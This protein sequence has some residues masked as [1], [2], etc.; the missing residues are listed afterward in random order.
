MHRW[1]WKVFLGVLLLLSLPPLVRAWNKPGHMVTGAIAYTVLKQESPE[2]LAK[3]V[4]ML[5]EHPYYESQWQPL[6]ERPFVPADQRDLYLFMLAAKWADDAR[7]DEDYYPP[8]AKRDLWHYVNIPFKPDSEPDD[9]KTR[10]FDAEFNIFTG[11]T[12][13]LSNL[14]SDLPNEKR[15]VALTWI[16]HLVGDAHQP[17]HS[18]TLFSKTFST[19]DRGGTLFWVRARKD[20]S[21][22]PLHQFWDGLII[23]TER[24]QTVRQRSTELWLRFK[25][26]ELTELSQ[27]SFDRWVREES[28]TLAKEAAYMN[29]KLPGSAVRSTAPPL[30]EGYIDK[31]QAI[32]ERRVVL[33]GY[34]LA[35]IL[36][37]TFD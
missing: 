11:Y 28:F 27:T 6:V 37:T 22:I 4:A 19:G 17:L 36:K 14:K 31:A 23:G 25:R 7:P 18:A 8:G 33:A 12:R 10:P 32:A 24:F 16:F 2:A 29:G 20:R 30:P 34:R 35:A 9:I 1:N 21:P 13:N 26:S 15:A 5:K 3:T